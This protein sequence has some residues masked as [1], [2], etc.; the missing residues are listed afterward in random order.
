MRVEQVRRAVQPDR[1][2]AGARR[3]LD[4]DGLM[5]L[6][7]HDH[8]LL[9][10]DG[11]DDV[12]HGSDARTFDLAL[13]DLRVALLL[14]GEQSLVLERGHLAVLEAETTAQLNAHRLRLA[15][16]VEGSADPGPPVDDHRV[17]DLVG[18]VAPTDVEA[19]A[20]RVLVRLVVV[21]AAEEERHGRVVLERLHPQVDRGLENL[22]ADPVAGCGCVEGSG[23][24]PHPGER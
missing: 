1:G 20:L 5:E 14:A 19:L 7:A 13:E 22:L 8:V 23:S 2:L 12:P 4:T 18:D 15:R 3:P 24:R 17:P 10:L 11:G 16:A 9:R 21:Q 6:G